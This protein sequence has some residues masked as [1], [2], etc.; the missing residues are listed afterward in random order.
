MFVLQKLQGDVVMIMR[1][2]KVGVV[3][4]FVT[5]FGTIQLRHCA[6][7]WVQLQPADL[8]ETI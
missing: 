6:A 1:C 3:S 5:S 4:I 2:V 8:A 7:R